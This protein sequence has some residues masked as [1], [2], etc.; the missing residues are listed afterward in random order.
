MTDTP[1]PVPQKPTI[2][3]QDLA[4]QFWADAYGKEV[5]SAATYS[6]MWMADQVGHMCLGILLTFFMVFV[7]ARVDGLVG[8]QPTEL[9]LEFAGFGAAALVIMAWEA[10]AYRSDVKKAAASG[11]KFPL[12]VPLLRWN[13]VAA[14]SYMI[15]G[16][17]IGWALHLPGW[18]ALG[19]TLGIIA[20]VVVTAL[21]WLRQKIIWQKAALPYL[22]RL[23]D[24]PHVMTDDD[25]TRLWSIVSAPAPPASKPEVIVIAGPVGSGRSA[26]SAGIG[27]EFA[28]K[29]ESV[30]YLQFSD[31]LELASVQD[32]E[33]QPPLPGPS[34]VGYW[35]WSEVQVLII[36]GMGPLIAASTN[37]AHDGHAAGLADVLEDYL[38]PFRAALARR[39]TIWIL[40]EAG[41]GSEAELEQSAD[42]IARF[43]GL[44][45][46]LPILLHRIH[47]AG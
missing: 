15:L 26:L 37:I 9:M 10:S 11:S 8:L 28:F 27:T 4:Q 5:Q 42:T 43:L 31:L 7:F 34:N 40:G 36:D 1:Q 47:S 35:P 25:A 19:I 14:A 21:P 39:H 2:T 13:A 45:N 16:A 18:Y 33:L 22:S 6:Y 41:G 3:N 23:A 38:A 17:G 44:G 32:F 29:A 20:L 30:R 24:L 46:P 12:D